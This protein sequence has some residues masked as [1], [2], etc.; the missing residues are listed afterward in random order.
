M[1]LTDL[2]SNPCLGGG[3]S[4]QSSGHV[5]RLNSRTGTEGLLV[6]SI[7]CDKPLY[8]GIRVLELS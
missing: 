5:T 4:A 7:N 1:A 6:S 3:V 2:G 8:S